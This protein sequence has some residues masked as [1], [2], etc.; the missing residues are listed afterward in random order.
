MSDSSKYTHYSWGYQSYY[1]RNSTFQLSN[2]VLIYYG[3][4]LLDSSQFRYY[5]KFD[6]FF[7]TSMSFTNEIVQRVIINRSSGKD[8]QEEITF[9]N[10]GQQFIEL[11]SSGKVNFHEGTIFI[12]NNRIVDPVSIMK[13]DKAFIATDN[14]DGKLY[15]S[16]VYITK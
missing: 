8:L 14:I 11:K 15:A 16:I 3:G 2:D 6:A 10:E 12:R 1:N 9:L 5:S 7:V 13:G 4:Q